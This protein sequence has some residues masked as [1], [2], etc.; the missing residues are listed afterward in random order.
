MFCAPEDAPF[1]CLGRAATTRST[2]SRFNL[3]VCAVNLTN[4][5]FFDSTIV[6]CEKDFSCWIPGLRLLLPGLG[7]QRNFSE[8]F[9]EFSDG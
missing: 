8:M 6:C 7:S 5:S 3:F 9:P 4:E 1:R 2:A